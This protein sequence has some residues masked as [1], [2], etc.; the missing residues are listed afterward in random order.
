MLLKCPSY[1]VGMFIQMFSSLISIKEY[2]RLWI[3]GFS[4]IIK[5]NYILESSEVFTI[6]AVVFLQW[7]GD[8]RPAI[9]RAEPHLG[10][11]L[12]HRRSQGTHLAPSHP[13]RWPRGALPLAPRHLLPRPQGVHPVC[14]KTIGSQARYG[15]WYS[16]M[17][18]VSNHYH[19]KC[20]WC[21]GV[22]NPTSQARYGCR[23][24]HT[25][26]RVLTQ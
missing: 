8:D 7:W 17:S 6:V 22:Q 9:T 11:V 20:M 26:S 18:C 25:M 21:V 10:Q 13:V 1:R 23:Y 14:L 12:C 3:Q 16:T 4:Q 19:D 24:Y 2:V 5:E 15:G